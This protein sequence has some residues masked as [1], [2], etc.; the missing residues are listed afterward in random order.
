MRRR[1]F[2]FALGS[3]V[4]VWPRVARTQQG[5]HRIG[6][7]AN[8]PT[9]P[10]Q[11]AGKAFLEGLQEHG[12]VEGKNIIIERRFA[13]GVSERS[14]GLATELIKLGVEL[15]VASG[16]NN[17]AALSQGAKSAPVVMVNVF[18]PIGM[19]IVRG[20]ETPGT[21]FTGL[22]SAVSIR[23]LGKSLKFLKQPFP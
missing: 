22:T 9:I 3:A 13:K 20:L 23:L 21:N 2:L 19:G 16:Q 17:I 1:E 4:A 6:F 8:D 10:M 5:I 15:F 14:S 7:L 18:D 12:F 11:A